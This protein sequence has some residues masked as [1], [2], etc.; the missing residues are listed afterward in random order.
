MIFED[1]HWT[2]PTSLE[3]VRRA[4]L[5]GYERL[6]VLLIVTYR[7][8]LNTA[9]MDGHHVTAL[10]LNRL[11]G[12]RRRG[13]I[14]GASDRRRSPPPHSPRWMPIRNSMRR[15]VKAGI[16]LDHAVLHL[17]GAAQ[18]ID[19][20]AEFDDAPIAGALHHA[21]MM[22]GNRRG[23]QIAPERAQPRK[24]PLLVSTGKLA[25][26]GYIRREDGC[27]F[28]GLR[29]GSPFTGRQSSTINGSGLVRAATSS[30]ASVV[31]IAKRDLRTAGCRKMFCEQTSSVGPRAQLEAAL[32]YCREGDTL[33]VTKLDRLARSAR[34]LRNWW[35]GLKPRGSRSAS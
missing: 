20:A 26:T 7:P 11:G 4:M 8:E 18:V 16:A 35:T 3:T 22:Q 15:S 1:A 12:A 21:P 33:V 34:H 17:D 28:P 25:V 30:F 32:D 19:D 31:M 24:R 6:R 14:D 13:M 10:T 5:I 27:K 23:N 2:D 29:H 9:S